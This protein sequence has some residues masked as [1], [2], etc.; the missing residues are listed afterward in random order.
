MRLTP[1]HRL[2][3]CLVLAALLCGCGASSAQLNGQ[4]AA[5][6]QTDQAEALTAGDLWAGGTSDLIRQASSAGFTL[7][8]V[9]QG[10]ITVSGSTS[11]GMPNDQFCIG[12]LKNLDGLSSAIASPSVGR[13]SSSL[14][15]ELAKA[16]GEIRSECADQS[17]F[18]DT[19]APSALARIDAEAAAAVKDWSA[20]H[21]DLNA[22]ASK[23]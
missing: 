3:P 11:A 16:I 22:A 19:Q 8:Q 10:E 1:V 20:A 23:H 5:A 2:A 21:A 12:V 18:F 17:T 14:S 4:A 6:I 9:L 7:S 13:L 15:S